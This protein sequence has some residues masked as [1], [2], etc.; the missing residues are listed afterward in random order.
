MEGVVGGGGGRH[1]NIL[2]TTCYK[3][4]FG[5]DAMTIAWKS[6][7]S[8]TVKQFTHETIANLASQIIIAQ[9]Q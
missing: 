2:H 3:R 1:D 5:F 9:K 8:L 7:R 4:Q 6:L